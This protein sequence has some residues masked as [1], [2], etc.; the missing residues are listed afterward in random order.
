MASIELLLKSGENKVLLA[1][2]E[3]RE[4]Y[5]LVDSEGNRHMTVK[6]DGVRF[7][8]VDDGDVIEQSDIL[9]EKLDNLALKVAD[10]NQ[11]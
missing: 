1:A 11:T 4:D 10:E 3:N 7:K 6:L 5:Y 9:N 2:T 8:I